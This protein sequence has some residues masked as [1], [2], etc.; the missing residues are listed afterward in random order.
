MLYLPLGR[1]YPWNMCLNTFSFPLFCLNLI[2]IF[3][4]P[5]FCLIWWSYFPSIGLFKP[6]CDLYNIS[7]N[8]PAHVNTS[9]Y[10]LVWCN[11]VT[12]VDDIPVATDGREL[13]LMVRLVQQAGKWFSSSLALGTDVVADIIDRLPSDMPWLHDRARRHRLPTFNPHGGP[14]THNSTGS[15]HESP[16]HPVD[17]VVPRAWPHM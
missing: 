2:I 9:V 3:S 7:S 17:K 15:K 11:P 10:H 14:I 1:I 8:I 12:I 4:F 16:V 5:L 6:Y 13:C